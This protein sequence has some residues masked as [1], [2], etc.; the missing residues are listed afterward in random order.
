MGIIR[1]SLAEA[2]LDGTASSPDGTFSIASWLFGMPIE[3]LAGGL[4]IFV[5]RLKTMETLLTCEE[6]HAALAR[7]YSRFEHY[8]LWW[9]L[10]NAD[11][12]AAKSL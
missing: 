5:M 1:R 4:V 12:A 3:S 7:S 6:V 8:V 9:Y 10:P 2:G 11:N